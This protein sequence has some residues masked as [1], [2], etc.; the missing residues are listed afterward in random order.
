MMAR[1]RNRSMIRYEVR[2]EN[3]EMCRARLFVP[4]N[5]A[6]RLAGI[7]RRVVFVLSWDCSAI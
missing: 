5:F 2:S 7:D 4:Q 3:Q 1:Q 6:D